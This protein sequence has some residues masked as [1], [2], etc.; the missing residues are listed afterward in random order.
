MNSS[1][2]VMQQ[3]NRHQSAASACAVKA[4]SA[5]TLRDIAQV[6][7]HLPG[8]PAYLR[9]IA[10][11]KQANALILHKA[12]VRL[13]DLFGEQ[14]RQL[15]GMVDVEDFDQKLAQIQQ[16]VRQLS[17]YLSGATRLALRELDEVEF[18]FRKQY[19]ALPRQ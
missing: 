13:K 14:V 18:S 17:P 16:D 2:F 9:A 7:R 1:F 8:V 3:I 10:P 19:Q 4:G 5:R 15:R 6:V 11:V 12:E